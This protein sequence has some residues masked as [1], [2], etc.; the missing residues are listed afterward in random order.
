VG[1]GSGVVGGG[2]RVSA[3]ALK[4]FIQD[5]TS[6]SFGFGIG[7]ELIK[8]MKV[9]FPKCVGFE[10]TDAKDGI[11]DWGVGVNEAVASDVAQSKSSD[12]GS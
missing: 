7:C 6:V 2:V 8:V 11:V 1:L 3:K 12:R 4:K 9:E 10:E 5:V